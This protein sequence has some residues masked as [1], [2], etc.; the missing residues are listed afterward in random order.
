MKHWFHFSNSNKTV[1][2]KIAI[3][4]RRTRKLT[5]NWPAVV[6]KALFV[7]NILVAMKT[8]QRMNLLWLWP[9]A[10]IA[11]IT[12]KNVK[13]GLFWKLVGIAWELPDFHQGEPSKF[14]GRFPTKGTRGWAKTDGSSG[15]ISLPTFRKI[16]AVRFS[17]VIANRSNPQIRQVWVKPL[18]GAECSNTAV[19]YTL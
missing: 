2:K 5:G 19:D 11:Y 6:Q 17:R 12:T 7:T 15:A 4:A 8:V 16:L 14:C 10:E 9:I 1:S 13:E 3:N 18:C